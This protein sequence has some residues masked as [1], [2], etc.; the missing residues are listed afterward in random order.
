MANERLRELR[1]LMK[2]RN[3]DAYYVPSSDFHDSEY[4]EDYFKCRAFL[5]GFTGSAGT[6]VITQAFS[7]MWTDGRYFVQAKKELEG[8][9]T[10]LMAMGEEGVPT[11]EEYLTDH[12]PEGGV[13]GFDGRV[14]NV[15]Q[16]RKFEAMM[17]K[18]HAT[19][20]VGDDLAGEVWE[21]RPILPAPEFQGKSGTN[22][23]GD[24]VLHCDH[25]VGRV[26]EK[27]KETR[28]FENT[29]LI[30]TS[31]NGCSPMANYE[32]LKAKGHNPS[33]VF[34]G[35]KADIY[36]GGHRI[37]LIVQWP[38]AIKA[39][40]CCDRIVCLSDL[41][42]T[43]A[44]VLGVDLP[45]TCAEDSVSNLPLWKDPGSPEVR[46]DIVHQS[47][48]G[49]L[50]IRRGQYKLE[51]CPGSGGWSDPIP[52]KED[53]TAPRFQL[54]DLSMDISER[55]NVIEDHLELASELKEVLKGYIENGRSTPGTP[56]SNNGQRI[57]NTIGWLD[58]E[59]GG[60]I[61]IYK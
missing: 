1:T 47:I 30:Y 11:I 14:V 12:M 60:E 39:G 20:S 43:M 51:L 57:W 18:K 4:V 21:E 27:L 6:M 40:G 56:Q 61:K 50:S 34:R 23:Y 16:G 59:D 48:D 37:P 49:S 10:R 44:D 33:Y 32:E 8:Q 58:E 2:V 25:V 9:D 3:V 53:T 5:S 29:I 41:M 7:G 42:A 46:K 52:G 54:Y 45:D 17:A 28:L 19:L 26:V 55:R 22:E 15:A 24:F 31:D 38:E 35:T 36:E 13:L